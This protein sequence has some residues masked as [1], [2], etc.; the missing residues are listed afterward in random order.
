MVGILFPPHR[1]RA[2]RCSTKGNLLIKGGGVGSRGGTVS[3]IQST[4][5]KNNNTAATTNSSNKA[6]W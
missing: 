2:W 4:T 5:A 6:F 1:K 3:H